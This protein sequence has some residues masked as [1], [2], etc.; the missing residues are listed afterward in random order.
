MEYLILEILADEVK[1]GN[2]STTQF[3]ASSFNRISNAINEQLGMN[4]TSKHVENHLKTIRNTWSTIQTLLNKSDFG[5]DDN[6][7]MITASPE[8]YAVHIQSELAIDKVEYLTVTNNVISEKVHVVCIFI[9]AVLAD[10][11]QKPETL[12]LRN[13]LVGSDMRNND[14]KGPSIEKDV[15][16]TEASQ[17]KTS[18]KRKRSFKVQ[19]VV[20][21]ISIKIGEVAMAIGRMVDSRLDVTKLYEEVMAMEDYSEEFLGDAFDYLVQSD[22]LA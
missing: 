2:K 12:N 6:L 3:K 5:W 4:F 9:R 7:K 22:T 10:V 21:D 17:I 18:R 15:Q 1:Q 13:V 16:V 14:V 8:V 19:D 11:N 20:G